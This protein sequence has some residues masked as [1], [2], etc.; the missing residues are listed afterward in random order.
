MHSR[1]S[2]PASP[3]RG[4]ALPKLGGPTFPLSDRLKR[5]GW[6]LSWLLLARWT[7]PQFLPLRRAL[8]RL[9]GA[10]LHPTANIRSSAKIWWP[11]HLEMGPHASLGPGV[12]CYN[13]APVVIEAD[14]DVSQRAHLCTASHDISDPT[15]PLV[16]CPITVRRRAWVAAEAFVGPGVVVGRG[17]VLAARA[18]TVRD[19]DDWTVYAGNPAR[20]VGT[21][22]VL[23]AA[24]ADAQSAA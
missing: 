11:A 20:P 10:R 15:F 21:R 16:S 8:L 23:E 1:F 18:V 12:I 7:P 14:A 24:P 17:A 2:D 19:L 5:L 22:P 9:Y 3:L 6:S 13:V 4:A